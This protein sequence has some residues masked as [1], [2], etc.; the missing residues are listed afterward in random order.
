MFDRYH[1]AV[2]LMLTSF[3]ERRH[4][5]LD[6]GLSDALHTDA[7]NHEAYPDAV[8]A[9]SAAANVDQACKHAEGLPRQ[10][11]KGL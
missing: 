1:D 11:R 7:D 6:H 9:Y 2:Y 5:H 3:P 4:M 10:A 8:E